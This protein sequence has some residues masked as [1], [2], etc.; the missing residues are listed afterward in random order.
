MERPRDGDDQGASVVMARDQAATLAT[1]DHGNVIPSSR[2]G[3]PQIP[4]EC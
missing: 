2:P 3:H 1:Y 4:I